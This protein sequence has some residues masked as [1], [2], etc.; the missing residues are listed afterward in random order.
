MIFLYVTFYTY[1]KS[2]KLHLK[3]SIRKI[4]CK[5]T[6]FVLIT[7]VAFTQTQFIVT[8]TQLTL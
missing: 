6:F 1:D 2:E 4:T 7:D 3:Q 8:E 5:K